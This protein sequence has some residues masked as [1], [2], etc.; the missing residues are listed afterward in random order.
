MLLVK[1]ICQQLH[2]PVFEVMS[3]PASELEYWECFFSIDANGDKPIQQ[4]VSVA[5]SIAAVKKILR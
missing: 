5:E 1:A 4:P 3:W 2:K